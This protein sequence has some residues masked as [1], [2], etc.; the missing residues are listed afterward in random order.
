[1][2]IFRSCYGHQDLQE[3]FGALQDERALIVEI[4]SASFWFEVRKNHTSEELHARK[5]ET[6][7]NVT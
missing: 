5:A 2:L 1:M 4:A 7:V 3:Q 6:S